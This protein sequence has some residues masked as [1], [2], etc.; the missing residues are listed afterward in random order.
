MT[1]FAFV[2]VSDGSGKVSRADSTQV[3]K[4]CMIG[5][6]KKHDSRRSKREARKKAAAQCTSPSSTL[7]KSPGVATPGSSSLL[8]VD[9]ALDIVPSLY[10]NRDVR[11][12]MAALSGIFGK[13]KD[14][15]VPSVLSWPE[16]MW[17]GGAVL[18]S[19]SQQLLHR[20]E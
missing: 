5:K 13:E 6:N 12:S 18:S 8:L 14:W 11:I 7:S 1:P 20:C 19:A 3:R 16:P 15:H 4:R 2:A 17:V 9:K 10:I